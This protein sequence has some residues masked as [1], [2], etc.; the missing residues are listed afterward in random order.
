MVMD[1]YSIWT[2]KNKLP[3]NPDCFVVLSYAVLNKTEPTT[4]T[5]AIIGLTYN[6]WKKFPQ[7]YVIMSTGDN[8]KL[9]VPNSKVMVDYALKLGIKENKLIQEDK[10][11]DTVTNLKNS[12]EII[13]KFKMK[14]PVIVTYDL[15]TRRMLAI[16]N[17]YRNL[18]FEYISIGGKG[19]P[20]YGI[21]TVQTHSRLTI[22]IYELLAYLYNWVKGQV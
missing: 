19:G 11:V 16:A 17:K 8:Q 3:V 12:W 13:K 10:S 15:H 14:N 7:A 2:V 1:I 6:W 18:N 22:L 20:A 5:K 9:G 4:P 21:K